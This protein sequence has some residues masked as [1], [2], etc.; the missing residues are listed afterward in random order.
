MSE[1]HSAPEDSPERAV[2][3]EEHRRAI[4]YRLALSLEALGVTKSE[5]AEAIGASPSKIGNWTA[6]ERDA[7]FYP[8]PY[9][10]GLLCDRYG[11][12]MDWLYRGRM[13]WLP[14][15]AWE[16]IVSYQLSQ[17]KQAAS[18]RRKAGRCNYRA[19]RLRALRAARPV[20]ATPGRA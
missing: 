6:H 3:T 4:A 10:L 15:V 13:D 8:D 1:P 16:K 9:L 20:I 14:H 11:L 19:R 5:A 7:L 12:T 2:G 18:G 17:L